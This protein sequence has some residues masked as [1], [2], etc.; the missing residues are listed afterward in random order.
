[1]TIMVMLEKLLYFAV[2]LKND[3]KEVT[4][5]IVASFIFYKHNINQ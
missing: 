1:M 4:I 3:A 2:N 5:Y